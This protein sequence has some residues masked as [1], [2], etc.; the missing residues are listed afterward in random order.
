MLTPQWLADLSSLIAVLIATFF[1]FKGF[2]INPRQFHRMRFS[3]SVPCPWV[4]YT[5][6]G[7]KYPG[8]LGILM[9]GQILDCFR[10]YAGY[11]QVQ[12][13]CTAGLGTYAEKMEEGHSEAGNEG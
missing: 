5:S 4:Y 12:A 10:I 3:P 7:R 8:N 13:W 1:G 11:N 9:S 2:H 6:L